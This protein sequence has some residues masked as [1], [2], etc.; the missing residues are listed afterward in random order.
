MEFSPELLGINNRNLKTFDVDIN[1]SINIKKMLPESQLTMSE[2][3]IYSRDDI[4]NLNKANIYNFLVG[5]FFMRNKEPYKAI[6]DLIAL[7]PISSR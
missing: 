4:N 5:E 7:S 3:G 6:Q 1:N 2:S